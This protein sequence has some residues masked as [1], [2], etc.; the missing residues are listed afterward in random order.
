MATTCWLGVRIWLPVSVRNKGCVVLLVELRELVASE[1][2]ARR[3]FRD[4]FE[5]PVLPA[6]QRPVEHAC[7]CLAYIFEAVNGIARYE[8]QCAGAVDRGVAV[9]RQFVAAINDK[10]NFLLIEV[11][12]VGRTF[13]GL[14][15][16]H[17]NGHGTGG[18]LGGQQDFHVKVERPDGRHL[19]WRRDDGLEGC[20]QGVHLSLLRLVKANG[21]RLVAR[22]MERTYISIMPNDP[23]GSFGK[24]L[25]DRMAGPGLAEINAFVAIAEQRSFAK[26]AL[27]LGVS[28]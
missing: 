4:F 28:V 18:V 12:M 15:P 10:E 16:C 5:V 6:R 14:V 11:E 24:S 23:N 26:A 2:T 1:A 27:R 9:N 8:D 17:D 21:C 7:R 20:N 3:K 13:A 19:F 25:T 22:D